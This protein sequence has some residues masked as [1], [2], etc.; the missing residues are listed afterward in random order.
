MSALS[1][2]V[3]FP[4]FQDRDGQPLENGYIWIGTANLSPQT[5]P[6]VAYYDSA[7]TIPAA[8][9][10]RTLNGYISRAG[11]PAQIYVDGAD[12]SILVQDS[13]GSM[14]YNFPSGTGIGA[15]ACGL[16]YNPPFTG[17]VPYPVCEKLEQ[18][19]SVKDFGAVG[20]GV[21]NDL[22]AFVAAVAASSAVYVPPGTYLCNGEFSLKSNFKLYGAGLA[23]IIKW[24]SDYSQILISNMTNVVVEDLLIDGGGQTTNIYTGVKGGNGVTIARS[25]N[26]RINRV[27]AQNMGIINQ[28]DPFG[29]APTYD[30][31]Y[32]GYGFNITARSGPLSNI[33]VTNCT[34]LR[35]AGAGYQK[36]DG[37]YVEGYGTEAGG[38]DSMDVV[39]DGCYA[40]V[41]GRHGYTVAGGTGEDVPSGVIF[42]NCYAEKTAL[43]GCDVES[44]YDVVFDNCIWRDCGN[45]QTYYDPVGEFG[46]TYTLLAAIAVDN[47]SKRIT[48]NNNTFDSCYY[49]FTYG[50][51]TDVTISNSTFRNST[52]ADISQGLAAGIQNFRLTNCSFETALDFLTYY[53]DSNS[54]GFYASGCLFAGKVVSRAMREG[55]FSGCRFLKGIE[56]QG[57]G[58]FSRRN[59]IVDS[60]FEDFAGSAIFIPTAGAGYSDF[61]ID[62]NVFNGAGNMVDGIRFPFQ[63]ATAWIVS[64]NKFIGLTGAGVNIQNGALF[65]YCDVTGNNFESCA[66]GILVDQSIK[67]SIFANNS[68]GNI[69]NNCIRIAN[70]FGSDPMLDGPS[71]MNN[72]ARAGCV[73]GISI[74]LSGGSYDYTM[75]VGN[76]V[77]ACSG[78]K[79]SLA[80]GNANGVVANNITT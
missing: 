80:A 13:K 49:G 62:G 6:V 73:N 79:F 9:P 7:L 4:V 71:I 58:G 47:S 17:A 65:H 66:N 50:A 30:V 54:S 51:S 63:S 33:R 12:F 59:R 24:G 69:S 19:V 5:N 76:N 40:S 57:G 74:A 14:V 10:L 22:A 43:D 34:A 77:H 2:Q 60:T 78:T 61:I 45:D 25:T 31:L 23:S 55:V 16:I 44:G 68:F 75:L 72:M 70:I 48:I 36:G 1:I 37:F 20:D 39:I 18:V 26:V 64:N 53:R 42:N 32:S 41:C 15:D 28:A 35:I 8:Q 21:A 29:V 27:T 46:A 38:T 3:P 11:T 67:Q 56:F 52:V